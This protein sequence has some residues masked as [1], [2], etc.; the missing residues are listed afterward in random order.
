MIFESPLSLVCDRQVLSKAQGIQILL[1]NG[2]G[3]NVLH[4]AGDVA[5]HL[6]TGN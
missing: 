2:A 5:M 4:L 6:Y 1:K 3:L